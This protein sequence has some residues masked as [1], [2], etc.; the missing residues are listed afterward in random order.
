VN[1]AVSDLYFF[2]ATSLT[3]DCWMVYD[4]ETRFDGATDKQEVASWAAM[5][6]NHVDDV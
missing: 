2:R 4:V 5:V 1:V 3:P 6:N